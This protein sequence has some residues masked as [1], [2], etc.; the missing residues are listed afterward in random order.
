VGAEQAFDEADK[1]T[2]PRDARRHWIRMAEAKQL[3]GQAEADAVAQRR[4]DMEILDQARKELTAGDWVKADQILQ[5]SS[6]IASRPG[7]AELRDQ[8]AERRRTAQAQAARSSQPTLVPGLSEEVR[9]QVQPEAPP[10]ILATPQEGAGIP[11]GS[12]QPAALPAT[13]S[14]DADRR[15]IEAVLDLYKSGYDT[16]SLATVQRAY[17]GVGLD[18]LE[19]AFKDL[20]EQRLEFINRGGIEFMGPQRALVISGFRNTQRNSNSRAQRISEGQLTIALHKTDAGWLIL[21]AMF[22]QER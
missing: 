20:R 3:Y 7:A 9:G 14:R 4:L 12:A 10:T 8:I 19:R 16:I 17:P 6:T 2:R 1:L 5:S 22:R 18:A 21:S 11:A 15:S 13:L